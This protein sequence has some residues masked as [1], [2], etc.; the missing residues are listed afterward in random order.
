MRRRVKKVL[1]VQRSPRKKR[2]KKKY[3]KSDGKDVGVVVVRGLGVFLLVLLARED[4]LLG[5]HILLGLVLCDLDKEA[6]LV[7]HILEG[8]VDDL[9]TLGKAM[10]VVRQTDLVTKLPDKRLSISQVV[11][12]HSREE[13]VDG[14]ELKSSVEPIQPG[15]AVDIHGG[16]EHLCRKGL[17]IAQLLRGHAKMRQRDLDVQHEGEHVRDKNVSNDHVPGWQ[18]LQEVRVPHPV[19]AQ[20]KDLLLPVGVHWLLGEEHH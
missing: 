18:L 6:D 2:K 3:C 17:T 13:M 4:N 20:A 15:G 8:R 12:R 1:R 5:V 16:A 10:D 7:C 9:V 14:L 11:A 19:N